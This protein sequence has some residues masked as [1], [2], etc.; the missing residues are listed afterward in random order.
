MNSYLELNFDV[1]QAATGNRYPDGADIR[2][3]NLGVIPLF[4][5]YKLTTSSGKHLEEIN[6]A[7]IVSLVFKLLSSSKESDDLSYGFDRSRDRK[8]REL[9]NNNNIKDK[10]HLRNCLR[11]F[12]WICRA[13]RNSNLWFG[14]QINVNTKF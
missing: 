10:Y 3:V 11:D 4:S 8:K 9:T 5:I 14:I 12:F 6:H 2:L 1:L 7:H 13:P